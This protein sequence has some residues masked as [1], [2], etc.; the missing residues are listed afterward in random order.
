MSILHTALTVEVDLRLP[1]QP[2]YPPF[3]PAVLN[4]VAREGLTGKIIFGQK[5]EGGDPATQT[6]GSVPE[7]GQMA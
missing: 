2:T 6:T 7:K 1:I 5:P 3:N 4:R